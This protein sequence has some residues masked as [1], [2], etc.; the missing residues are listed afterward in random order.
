MLPPPPAAMRR[1]VIQDL[2][3]DCRIGVY[4]HERDAAQRVRLNF[5]LDVAGEA[6]LAEEDLSRVVDYDQLIG[7]IRAFATSRHFGLVE[8][9]AEHLAELC[10][11][12]VRIRRA[13]VRV[14]KLQA[15]PDAAAVGIEV[16]RQ[17][18]RPLPRPTGHP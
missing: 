6:N 16:E 8:V 2:T 7:R 4:P 5:D 12:D 15:I 1:L 11:E 10:L 18:S 9:L 3:L 13:R 17:N 14:D